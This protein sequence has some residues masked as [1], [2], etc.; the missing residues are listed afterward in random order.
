VS[1]Q[2]VIQPVPP[3]AAVTNGASEYPQGAGTPYD[4]PRQ[5]EAPTDPPPESKAKRSALRVI[6][7]LLGLVVVFVVV[8]TATAVVIMARRGTIVLPWQD[9]ASPA[10]SPGSGDADRPHRV[11]PTGSI[12]S[13]SEGRGTESPQ[14]RSDIFQSELGYRAQIPS[15]WQVAQR[16][17]RDGKEATFDSFTNGRQGTEYASIQV[18]VLEA[19]GIDAMQAASQVAA[20]ATSQQGYSIMVQPKKTRFANLDAASFRAYAVQSGFPLVVEVYVVAGPDGR[21]IQIQFASSLEE[22]SRQSGAISVFQQGFE[23]TSP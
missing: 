19:P 13:G 22:F 16:A 9:R 17:R 5:P 15:G 23:F 1:D 3:P 7:L 21:L 10:E 18:S 6:A 12:G 8:A 11:P 2:S 4:R 20:K 14:P